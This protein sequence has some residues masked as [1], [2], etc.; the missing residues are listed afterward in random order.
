MGFWKGKQTLKVSF[1]RVEISGGFRGECEVRSEIGPLFLLVS[2]IFSYILLPFFQFLFM[3]QGVAKDD[4]ANICF[5]ALKVD[6]THNNVK[7]QAFLS[8]K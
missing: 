8:R 2:K 4:F 6:L 3:R 1:R 5:S 7:N